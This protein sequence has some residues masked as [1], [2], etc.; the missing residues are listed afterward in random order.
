MCSLFSVCLITKSRVSKLNFQN[1]SEF[2]TIM[3]FPYDKSREHELLL[4]DTYCILHVTLLL[5]CVYY[6]TTRIRHDIEQSVQEN[7]FVPHR[8]VFNGE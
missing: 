3:Y 4:F 2:L 1:N 5:S 8:F 6:L 7:H